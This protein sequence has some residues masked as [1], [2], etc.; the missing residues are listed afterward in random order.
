MVESQSSISERLPRSSLLDAILYFFFFYDCPL[1]NEI[2]HLAVT[3]LFIIDM[4]VILS[5]VYTFYT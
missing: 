3:S 2:W 5:L 1:P 4:T